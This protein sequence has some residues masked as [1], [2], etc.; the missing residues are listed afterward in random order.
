MRLTC[1]ICGTRDLREFSYRGAATLMQRPAADAGLEAFHAYVH[2]RENPAGPHAELWQHDG[3]C[4]AWLRVE[5]DTR[6]HAIADV[7]LARAEEG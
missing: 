2:I 5:R 7:R 4:R 6:T 3:G 1:P